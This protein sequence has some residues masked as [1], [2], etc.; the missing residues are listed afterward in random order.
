M[1]CVMDLSAGYQQ[2]P[3]SAE[4]RPLLTINTHVGLFEY[5]R[6]PFSVASAP[7]IFQSFTDEALEDVRNVGCDIDDVIVSG[8]DITHYQKTL[9]RVLSRLMDHNVTLKLEKCS[10]FE[11]TVSQSE[12]RR[13]LS[14]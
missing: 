7:A 1:F 11:R 14:H 12:C 6:L 10:F 3:L 8:K 9:E 13:D 4:S 5:Q 2:V